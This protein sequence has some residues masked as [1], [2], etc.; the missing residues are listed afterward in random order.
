MA[1]WWPLSELAC[2]APDASRTVA[3]LGDGRGLSHAD[4]LTRVGCWQ[5]A[6]AAQVVPEWAL[7]LN[8]PFEF[9][10][11]LLAAWHAG[12]TVVLPGDDLPST[13]DALL[14]TGCGL[15]GDLPQALQASAKVAREALDRQPIDLHVA[16]LKVYTSGS[17]G[18]PEAIGKR[19]IQL[20]CEVE[21]LESAF[22]AML[23]GDGAPGPVPTIWAT[24]SHQHIYGLLFLVLWPLAAG[25]P[26]AQRRLL[27]PE[28]LAACLGPAPSVLVATPAHLKRLGDQLDWGL[29]RQGL[30]AVF[31]SGGP[32]PFEVSRA[33]SQALGHVPTEVFGSSETGGIAWRRCASADQAWQPF[34]KVQWRLD[35]G[36]CLAVQSPH[37]PDAKWWTTSDRAESAGAGSFRLLGR[38]DR[39]VKIEEK[40]VSLSAIEQHLLA[41]PWVREARALVIDTPI[42][43]RVAVVAVPTPLG[44]EHANHGRRV[45]SNLLRQVLAGVVEAVVLPRRWRFVE[46]LPINAQGKSPE[47][48]LAALFMDTPAG[49]EVDGAD[50]LTASRPEMPTVQW[51]ERSETAALA[52]L[53]IHA[54]LSVFD[55]HFEVAPILPGVAQLDWAMSL[56]RQCFAMPER[57]VRL[58]VLKFV[59]PVPPGTALKVALQFKPRLSDASLCSLS[60]KLYSHDA[61]TQEQLD[62]ASGRSVWSYGN[63]DKGEVAHA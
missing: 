42:G 61:A 45:L 57:F 10:A 54:G 39:I 8:D 12:K 24:V 6:F 53:D 22:G 32:L 25:R 41:T 55:G 27:Y 62:H 36:G 4:F 1:D 31:S 7:Y 59:R 34:D 28:D 56:G 46:A 16:G 50:A 9:A 30:R 23:D 29:A 13:V 37:L 26:L 21:A 2:R 63:T 18:R 35:E 38:A 52:T 20:A 17:Q 60:F 40:R 58:E 33:V 49:D 48:L 11:A 51:D 19:L 15:A 3:R 43:A 47:A 14:A 44:R 5:S